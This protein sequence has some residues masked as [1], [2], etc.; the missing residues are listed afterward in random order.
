MKVLHVAETFKGGVAT[1]INSLATYQLNNNEIDG[2][3]VIV[4]NEHISEISPRL[5]DNVT[6]FKRKKRGVASLVNLGIVLYKKIKIYKPDIIHLHSTFAGVIGRVLIL[7]LFNNKN[8][9]VVYCPHAFPFLMDSHKLKKILYIKCEK[10]LS[11][12]TNKIICVGDSEYDDAS[13]AG[14][15]R[16]KMVVINNGVNIP[17]VS[18][19][20]NCNNCE[21]YILL[22]V[23]RFDYQKGTDIFIEALKIIDSAAL[24]YKVKVIMVGEPVNDSVDYKNLEF[25][26]INVVFTGWINQESLFD[27]YLKAN[28]LVIPSRWEGLAMVPLEAISYK[29]PV[30][31]SNISAFKTINN[32]SGLSFTNEDP[33]SLAKLLSSLN[34]YD[35]NKI[36]D[37]LYEKVVTEYTQELMN[38]K[39]FVVYKNALFEETFK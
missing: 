22:Y 34:D 18:N 33:A 35:L 12:Y 39:T 6:T 28:C 13:L 20:V 23:G 1:V 5:K 7:T 14:I 4:P 38:D 10:I 30:I 11:K 32:L 21:E 31:A 26:N 3:E 9:K 25:K 15:P 19:E 24:T 8:I 27:Y 29:L 37:I 17:T 2:V 16:D 36:K